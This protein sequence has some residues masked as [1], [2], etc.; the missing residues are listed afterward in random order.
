MAATYHNYPHQNSKTL[1]S[2][3]KQVKY[4]Q[5]TPPPPPPSTQQ[6]TSNEEY[7]NE[8]VI[9]YVLEYSQKLQLHPM[10][11]KERRDA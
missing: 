4:V 10:V 8:F 3:M 1:G 5:G 6:T 7:E 11:N 2:L 9:S